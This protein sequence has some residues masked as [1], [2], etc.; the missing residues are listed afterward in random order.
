MYLLAPKLVK[1]NFI[2]P[3]NNLHYS[4]EIIIN[5]CFKV[6]FQSLV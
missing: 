4:F 6:T 5:F 3:I 2:T 1:I